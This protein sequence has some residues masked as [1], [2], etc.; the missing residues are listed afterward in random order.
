[1]FLRILSKMP[2][3]LPAL[4]TLFRCSRGA[5]TGLVMQLRVS[6]QWRLWAWGLPLH[7]VVRAL[8]LGGSAL[9]LCLPLAVHAE[10]ETG[11]IDYWI[12]YMD[13]CYFKLCYTW[14]ITIFLRGDGISSKC[15][16]SLALLR[17]DLVMEPWETQLLEGCPW[18][19]VDVCVCAPMVSVSQDS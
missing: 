7:P 2:R 11:I 4:L 9:R 1:M 12:Y 8:V 10:P 13:C 6:F 16:E 5:W 15:S 14:N 3:F 19:C 18:M 17:K